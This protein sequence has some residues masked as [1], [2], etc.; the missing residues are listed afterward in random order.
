MAN[1]KSCMK[2]MRQAEKQR[3][4]NRH[5]RTKMKHSVRVVRLALDAGDLEGAKTALPQAISQVGRCS[6]KGV[7]PSKRASR[8]ISRLTKA[9]NAG[10]QA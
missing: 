4:R 6:S 3:A 8:T 7:I 10:V 1:T 5:Y 2:R 9:V